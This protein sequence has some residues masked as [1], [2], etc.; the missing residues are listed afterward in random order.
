MVLYG[1]LDTYTCTPSHMCAL[2]RMHRLAWSTEA[3]ERGVQLAR[4][5]DLD[6]AMPLYQQALQLDPTNADAM[7]AQG[8]AMA[9]VRQYQDAVDML[10]HALGVC[11]FHCVLCAVSLLQHCIDA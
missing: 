10:L 8:A 2:R 9:N 1:Q 6:A 3:L 7:V 5:G 4:S 11:C